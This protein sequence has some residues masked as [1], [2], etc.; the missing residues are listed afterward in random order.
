MRR[1]E[2]IV[3]VGCAAASWPFT[4]HA[5]QRIAQIGFLS[6]APPLDLQFYTTFLKGLRDL[7]YVEGENVEIEARYSEYGQTDRLTA[8]ASELVT[9][10]VD[11][12]VTWGSGVD[13]AHKATTTVPT[14]AVTGDLVALG[15]ADSLAHPGGNVTGE[16]FFV[17]ELYVKRIALL[18]E[19]KPAMTSVGLLVAQG[20]SSIPSLLRAIDAPVKALGVELEPIEV[21]GPNDC[22]RALSASRG[23]SIG[24]LVLT[25]SAQFSEF[26]G[27][28]VAVIAA[29]ATRHG[30]P[31][32]GAP[33]FAWYGGL[34]GY[35]VDVI[36]M[37]RRAATFVDKILKGAK[38]GDLPIEQ[39]TKFETSVNL[40]TAKALGVDMPPTLLAAADEVIE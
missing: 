37:F 34:L 23:A 35:G 14:V 38:P 3:A 28:G 29:A 12:I 6:P 25:D 19:V 1:R 20:L 9:L 40:T 17:Q 7:G 18:K 26:S 4:A 16:T 13:A 5:D 32:A 36:P 15:L 31:S 8:H 39:A 10:K 30:V 24:G 11:V 22:D 33:I 27:T 21:A 2:F